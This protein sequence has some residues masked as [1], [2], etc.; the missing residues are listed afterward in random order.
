MSTIVFASRNA[1]K[2]REIARL[3]ELPGLDIVPLSE[4]LG[5]EIAIEETGATFEE[6]A[7]IKASTVCTLTQRLSLADDSGLEV[8]ALGGRPGV[9]SARFAG[10]SATDDDNNRLLVSSLA[11]V[12]PGLRGAR[13]VAVLTLAA[14]EDGRVVRV[15]RGEGTLEGRIAVA[16]RGNGGFGYDCLFEPLSATGRSDPPRTTAEMT[17]AEKNAI[18]HRSQAA[19]ALRP[20]LQAW[21]ARRASV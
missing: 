6:N 12:P 16:P 20:A 3:L 15:A 1:G 19:R 4:V 7:W 10:L 5:P 11:G 9:H 17:L 8:D 14:W 18:S 2:A 13:F 21:L